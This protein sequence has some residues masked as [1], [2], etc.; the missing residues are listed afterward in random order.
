M[1]LIK[2]FYIH[3]YIS[4]LQGHFDIFNLWGKKN[5]ILSTKP[6]TRGPRFANTEEVVIFST[7]S[8]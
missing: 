3:R 4:I 6:V 8:G 5:K 1:Y 2:A 7:L